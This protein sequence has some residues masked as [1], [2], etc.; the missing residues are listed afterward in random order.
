MGFY[1]GKARE[2]QLGTDWSSKMCKAWYNEDKQDMSWLQELQHCPCNLVQALSD[3]GRWQ[4]DAGC[5]LFSSSPNKCRFH[6]GAVHCVR[7]VQPM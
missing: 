4:T 3:I 6:I 2:L 5:S 1:V 7:A